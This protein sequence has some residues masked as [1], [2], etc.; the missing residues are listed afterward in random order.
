MTTSKKLRADYK[1]ALVQ[2]AQLAGEELGGAAPLTGPSDAEVE[3]FVRMSVEPARLSLKLMGSL[4]KFEMLLK[5]VEARLDAKPGL[6]L[7]CSVLLLRKLRFRVHPHVYTEH[8]RLRIQLIP[9]AVVTLSLT[10]AGAVW[11]GSKKLSGAALGGFI[12]MAAAAALVA[13]WAACCLAASEYTKEEVPA[14]TSTLKDLKE[15]EAAVTAVAEKWR[16]DPAFGQLPCINQ[17]VNNTPA[18][19]ERTVLKATRAVLQVIAQT[20]VW[21]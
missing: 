15:S 9:A 18:R 16:T 2:F 3:A 6:L 17:L 4:V 13:G 1:A 19:L 7:L 11:F 21:K 5:H 12:P 20:A 10:F 8:L 14:R